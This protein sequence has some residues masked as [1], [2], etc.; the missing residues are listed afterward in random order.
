MLCRFLSTLFFFSAFT[1]AAQQRTSLNDF[2]LKGEICLVVD[3]SFLEKPRKLQ[4]DYSEKICTRQ[5]NSAGQIEGEKIYNPDHLLLFH[6]IYRYDLSGNLV[7]IQYLDDRG[8]LIYEE[9]RIHGPYNRVVLS[10]EWDLKDTIEKKIYAYEKNSMNYTEE[11]FSFRLNSHSLKKYFLNSKG[12]LEKQENYT[13]TEDSTLRLSLVNTFEYNKLGIKT[14]ST[15]NLIYSW[16]YS[17]TVSVFQYDE[18]RNPINQ[19]ITEHSVKNEIADNS[20]IPAPV[21]PNVYR[22]EYRYDQR[23]N[24]TERKT[25]LNGNLTET[26]RR[27]ITYD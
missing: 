10:Y 4:S 8:Q 3:S 26:T 13:Y 1:S 6:K 19:E 14:F 27:S 7:K 20:E 5:F 21:A 15:S 18:Y 2:N 12:L 24:W 25:Y 11:C 9:I 22:Y 16:G 23:G 17:G